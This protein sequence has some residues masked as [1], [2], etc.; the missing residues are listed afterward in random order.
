MDDYTI[1]EFN[2]KTHKYTTVGYAIAKNSELAKLKFIEDSGW[3]PNRNVVL[4][5]KPPLC[6]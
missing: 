3:K 1:M 6:R 5:A 2:T 4:F